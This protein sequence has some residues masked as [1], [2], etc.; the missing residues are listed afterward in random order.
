MRLT[1]ADSI[2]AVPVN[3]TFEAFVEGHL[4]LEAEELFSER[5]VKTASGLAIGFRGVP[6]DLT[7]EAGESDNLFRKFLYCDFEAG[8]DI[9][10]FGA[11]VV[12]GSQQDSLSR[13]A[14][15]RE[16]ARGLAGAP[17]DYMVVAG[18][19]GIDAFFYKGGDY[20]AAI[21]VEIIARAVEVDGN[22]EYAVEAIFG[23]IGLGLDE[24]HFFGKP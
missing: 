18:I 9:D 15:V 14:G 10:R 19:N 7:F 2:F 20:V 23:A 11:V 4:R 21:G 16:L 1:S 5:D 17:A 8:A 12:F 3:C 24:K 13:V 6:A 22:K